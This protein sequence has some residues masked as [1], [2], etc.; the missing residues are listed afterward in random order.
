MSLPPARKPIYQQIRDYLRK[1]ILSGRWKPG[2]R[3]PSENE[4]SAQFGGSRITVKQA[5][6]ELVKEELVYRIQ[7]R[8]TFVAEEAAGATAAFVRET[9]A[10]YMALSPAPAMYPA[11]APPTIALII[12][13]SLNTMIVELLDGIEE[14]A[15]EAGFRLLFMNARDSGDRELE[16]LRSASESGAKGIILFP[17]HG[18]SYNEEVLRLAM[19]HYPV[20]VLD[21]YLRGVETNCVCSDNRDGAYCGTVH[22]IRQGHRRIGCVT[23]P[24][25]GTTSLEDRLY[26]YEQALADHH[27]PVDHSARLHELSPEAIRTFLLNRNGIT[28]LIVF[29]SVHGSRI[30]AAAEQ[31]GIRIPEDLSLV[32]FDDYFNADLFRVPPTVIVQPFRQMGREAARLLLELI[33]NPESERRKI[34]LPTTLVERNSTAPPKAEG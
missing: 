11:S 26:G 29:D 4:L 13:Y 12:Q 20:V 19:R 30:M 3:L 9:P 15:W 2:D 34:M 16:M 10:A 33:R 28:A 1:E 7:G 23:S 27:I 18:E 21:R 14:A 32:I 17:A 22:L 31:L 5:L 6:A 25:L 24:V 8:G